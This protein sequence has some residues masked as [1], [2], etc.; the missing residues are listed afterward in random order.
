MSELKV[1]FTLNDKDVA[2]LRRLIRHAGARAKE[3]DGDAIIAAAS[4]LVRRVREAKPPR[5][6]LEQVDK[7][8][9]IV[10]LAQDKD[11][12]LPPRTRQ[13][14][15]TALSYFTS[16][17]DLIPDRIP[18]LGYLDDAIMIELVASDLAPEL[19]GYA[20]YQRFK[21]GGVQRPWVASADAKLADRKRT[22]RARIAAAEAKPPKHGFR[23]W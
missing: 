18:G 1:T 6:V 8:E 2:F 4:D 21:H 17:H 16:T 14:V 19:K 22:L 5:Y 23:L 15:L 10:A 9:G 7:L 11:W 12:T 13:R 20:E 3:Q